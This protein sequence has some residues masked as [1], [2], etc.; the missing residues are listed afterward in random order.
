[1]FLNINIIM[2]IYY[3]F[4]ILDNMVYEIDDLFDLLFSYLLGLYFLKP[5]RELSR[6]P[7]LFFSSETFNYLFHIILNSVRQ[8]IEYKSPWMIFPTLLA[9][10]HKVPVH[11]SGDIRQSFWVS[12]LFSLIL[13]ANPLLEQNSV[14]I[15]KVCSRWLGLRIAHLSS[16]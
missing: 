14:N 5:K 10:L 16:M 6:L 15:N 12:E 13:G 3:C 9:S 11:V 4:I 2:I 1:M 8:L 7:L